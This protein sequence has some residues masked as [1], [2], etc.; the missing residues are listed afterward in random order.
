MPPFDFMIKLA[1][2]YKVS[3]DYLAGFKSSPDKLK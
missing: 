3:L 1:V 2:Y